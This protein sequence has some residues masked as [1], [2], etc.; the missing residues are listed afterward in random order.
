MSKPE[1]ELPPEVAAAIGRGQLIEAI[2][3]LRQARGLSL[4]DAKEI[5][6]TAQPVARPVSAADFSDDGLAP[7]EQRQR[8]GLWVALVVLVLLGVLLF[9]WI[10]G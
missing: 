4:K 7:G 6:D 5:V 2:K 10:G 9:R 3:L 1:Q 8:S